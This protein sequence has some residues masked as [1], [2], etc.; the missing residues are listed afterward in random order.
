MDQEP[1]APPPPPER[2]DVEVVGKL[3]IRSDNPPN[4]E[5]R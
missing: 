5:T 2:P 3:L 1:E 4:V